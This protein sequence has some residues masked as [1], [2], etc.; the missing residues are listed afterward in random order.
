LDLPKETNGNK[1]AIANSIIGKE[2]YRVE[3]SEEEED[4]Y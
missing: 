3:T 2:G 1:R 4:Q